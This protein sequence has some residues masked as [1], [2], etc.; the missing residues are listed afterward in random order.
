MLIQMFGAPTCA[1][2]IEPL[3][4]VPE[5][6]CGSAFW[7]SSCKQNLK[8]EGFGNVS[9]AGLDIAPLA[10]SLKKYGVNWRF[11]LQN[12]GNCPLEL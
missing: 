10:P 9:F 4:R 2:S 11:V 3:K 8:R 7:S 6:A 12:L 1:K 5:I